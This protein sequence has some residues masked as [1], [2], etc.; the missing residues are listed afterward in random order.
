LANDTT[1]LIDTSSLVSPPLFS[2][3]NTVRTP[4]GTSI[5]AA[6]GFL[7]MLA[8]LVQGQDPH[9][10]ACA[11]DESWRPQWRVE[12]IDSY[13]AHPAEPGSPQLEAEEK[14]A[15]QMPVL[16]ELLRLCGIQ[17]VGFPDYEAED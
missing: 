2:P 13:K 1:L 8:R 14:L 11:T 3:P 5:N 7:G 6:H 15:P 17:V 16:F 9:F 10:I 12:L 4:Q